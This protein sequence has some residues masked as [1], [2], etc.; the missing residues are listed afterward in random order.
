MDA[1]RALDDAVVDAVG[2]SATATGLAV[3][4]QEFGLDVAQDGVVREHPVID[5]LEVAVRDV[6][7]VEVAVEAQRR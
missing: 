2:V 4:C 6:E 1:V 5:L 3:R 7:P